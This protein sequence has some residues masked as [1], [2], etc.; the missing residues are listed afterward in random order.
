MRRLVVPV[1]SVVAAGIGGTLGILFER[2]LIVRSSFFVEFSAN[3]RIKANF[4]LKN[5][6]PTTLKACKL[7]LFSDCHL[8]QQGTI[9]ISE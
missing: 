4:A 7:T 8:I 9:T 5:Y 1:V 6:L 2:Y 3:V